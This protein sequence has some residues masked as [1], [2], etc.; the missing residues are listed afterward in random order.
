MAQADF[1]LCEGFDRCGRKLRQAKAGGYIPRM[2]AAFRSNEFDGILRLLKTQE[3]G[4]ALRLVERMHV[5]ALEV[6]D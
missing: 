6:F 4:E 3:R 1:V 5:L 2:L